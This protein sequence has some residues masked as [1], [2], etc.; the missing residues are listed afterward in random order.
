MNIKMIV[1]D[2]DGTLLNDNQ[3]ISPRTYDALV[4]AQ[5]QGVMVVLASGRSYK[6]LKPYGD[7]L[8]M[9]KYNG[10]YICANGASIFETKTDTNQIVQRLQL[11]EIQEIY[12]TASSF[13]VE[14]MGVLDSTIYDYIPESLMP[15]KQQYRLENKIEDD[16]PWTAG[17]FKMIV[18]QRKGYSEIY[19]I[20]NSKEI[21]V[22]VNKICIAHT[23]EHLVEPYQVLTQKL[24]H[25]YNFARTSP[26]WIE[27]TPIAISKGNAI[28]T[29]AKEYNINKDE[30][31]VFGDGE[32]DLSM[33]EAVTYPI[34]M[35]N[36]MDNVK[37][38]AYLVTDD[39]N[40]DGIAKVIEKEVLNK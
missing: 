29:L 35:A 5:S 18:D 11:D 14:I 19:Y 37:A 27:C 2:M 21:P 13:D 34:A 12:D 10:Y 30:I 24:G 23:V 6:T 25:K 39:N 15:L 22:P 8:L 33:F 17:T 16:V 9:P 26:Q 7:Y 31:L 1:M 3:N 38:K 20:K 40:N 32:N 28:S 36:A 4:K